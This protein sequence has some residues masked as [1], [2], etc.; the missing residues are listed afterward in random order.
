MKDVLICLGAGLLI[1]V[2]S[3]SA[4]YLLPDP[5]TRVIVCVGTEHGVESCKSLK[6]LLDR[7]NARKGGA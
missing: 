1:G 6:S 3:Q 2:G 5:A 4:K 7:A